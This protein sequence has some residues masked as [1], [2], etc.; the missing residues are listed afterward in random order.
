MPTEIPLSKWQSHLADEF[1]RATVPRNPRDGIFD[2]DDGP[3]LPLLENFSRLQAAFQYL[4]TELLPLWQ[5]ADAAA[6]KYQRQHRILARTVIGTGTAAVVL[7]ILQMAV[8]RQAPSLVTPALTLEIL[9]VMAGTIAVT[10]G[11]WTKGDRHWLCERN[12]AER[13]RILKFKALGWSEL[14]LPD[15][16][17]WQ[18]RLNGEISL[19]KQSVAEVDVRRWSENELAQPEP[20]FTTGVSPNGADWP[21]LESYFLVKRLKFQSH[22]YENSFKLHHAAARPW[23]HLSLPIFI[24]SNIC[25]LIHFIANRLS[26]FALNHSLPPMVQIWEG[27]GIWSLALA[28]IIPVIGLGIRVWLGAFEPHRSSNLHRCK[29]QTVENLRQQMDSLKSLPQAWFQHVAEV[30]KFFENEHREWL[31]LMLETEW[32]M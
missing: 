29:H 2:M 4:Q 31:R 25:I 11:L 23:R 8:A 7:A 15:P 17:P 32:M 3:E 5:V 18:Q 22:Y 26:D 19:L 28:A 1:A 10:V 12:R 6:M 27:V 24:L 9:A 20:A 14:W 30:E 13:L 16:V 21:A